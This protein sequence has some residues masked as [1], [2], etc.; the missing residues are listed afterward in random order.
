MHPPCHVLCL[1]TIKKLRLAWW[2][3]SKLQFSPQY[4]H[5]HGLLTLVFCV[6]TGMLD[7]SAH[8]EPK[9][10]ISQVEALLISS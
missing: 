7:R 2:H 4:V 5:M 10:H 9:H 3:T 6:E 1:I 8:H